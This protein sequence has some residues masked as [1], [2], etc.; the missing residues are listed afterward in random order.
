MHCPAGFRDAPIRATEI[1]PADT[2][3]RGLDHV[4]EHRNTTVKL[5]KFVIVS[6]YIGAISY[7]YPYNPLK[8]LRFKR[9]AKRFHM[10]S[11]NV[12]SSDCRSETFIWIYIENN[13]HARI[14][15]DQRILRTIQWPNMR[16]S[17]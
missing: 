5:L 4:D 2:S 13:L 14:R 16:Q 12:I 1:C 10:K 3:I 6:Q 9:R 8:G 17:M 15:R 11:L 7:K